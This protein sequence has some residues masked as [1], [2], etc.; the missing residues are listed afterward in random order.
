MWLAI[1]F[2][3]SIGLELSCAA[4]GSRTA[5]EE[6]L[7]AAAAGSWLP[8]LHSQIN[9]IV[10][11]TTAQRRST[12]QLE[13]DRTAAHIQCSLHAHLPHSVLPK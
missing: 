5:K 6:M 10:A 3:A 11:A 9:H 4:A 7:S 1:P 8:D 12:Q 2:I 13:N